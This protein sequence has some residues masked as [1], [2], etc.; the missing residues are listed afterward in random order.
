MNNTFMESLVVDRTD[1]KSIKTTLEKIYKLEVKT[2][3]R[4]TKE[5]KREKQNQKRRSGDFKLKNLLGITS[6]DQRKT[7][8]GILG[9]LGN[10]FKS[11]LSIGAT[12]LLV[13][14]GI[15]LVGGAVVAY[16]KSEEFRK[17]VNE[18]VL[19]PLGEA[20]AK[21]A[22][23]LMMAAIM[24]AK[25]IIKN[26]TPGVKPP[27]G[28][29]NS[30]KKGKGKGKGKGKPKGSGNNTN[31][32]GTGTSTPPKIKPPGTVVKKPPVVP[33]SPGR[34]PI[35]G[36]T[37]QPLPPTVQGTTPARAP[38]IPKPK[39]APKITPPK[40]SALKNI[41]GGLKS[42]LSPASLK[43]LGLSIAVDAAVEKLILDPAEKEMMKM[44]NKKVAGMSEEEKTKYLKKKVEEYKKEKKYQNHWWH[45]VDKIHTLGAPTQSEMKTDKIEKILNNFG[46]QID[47]KEI[48]IEE[49]EPEMLQTGGITG[50]ATGDPRAKLGLLE[51]RDYKEKSPLM[52]SPVKRQSGGLVLFAGHTD[53]PA[54]HP[55]PGTDAPGTDLQ[56]KYRPTAE[57]HFANAVG[58]AA[59]SLAQK[60]NVPLSFR[61]AKGQYA[62]TSD[63]NSNWAQIKQIRRGGGSAIDLHYDAYGYEG[64]RLIQGARGVISNGFTLTDVEKSVRNKFGKHPTSG[65]F[66]VPIV[67]LDTIN[68]APGNTNTYARMLVDSV[69]NVDSSSSYQDLKG[70][71]TNTNTGSTDQNQ[72]L[73]KT[74]QRTLMGTVASFTNPVDMISNLGKAV[75]NFGGAFGEFVGSAL[76]MTAS[77][78]NESQGDQQKLQTGGV[79]GKPIKMKK[80]GT[81]SPT[82]MPKDRPSVSTPAPEP[83]KEDK[84]HKSIPAPRPV[85]RER[86]SSTTP[87]V[88]PAPN[89]SITPPKTSKFVAPKESTPKTAP[90]STALTPPK[91]PTKAPTKSSKASPIK[92]QTTTPQPTPQP[93]Q[94]KV[95][96]TPVSK[97]QKGGLVSLSQNYHLNSMGNE[98]PVIIPVEFPSIPV[99]GTSTKT[100]PGSFGGVGSGVN[101]S[102]RLSMG[103]AFS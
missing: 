86:Q 73:Q 69:K 37:G 82:K 61:P 78:F 13:A 51:N 25:F 74:E 64:G 80:G 24:K 63:P 101:D 26:P 54:G 4:E 18:K 17:H 92:S 31:P 55:Q 81:P 89:I 83:V 3:K 16:I 46:L 27:T 29:G 8:K 62:S 96:R 1:I 34:S 71:S 30:N 15:G 76:E 9:L 93:Q 84:P 79:V 2:E 52:Q 60:E 87:Q 50:D 58:R 28:S 22:P 97:M 35:L 7:K 43:T 38:S 42:L 10:I 75:K 85:K 45:T 33:V 68:K 21:A 19:T 41:G 103:A 95:K 70:G 88:P 59:D 72:Q 14:A 12:P 102:Y 99:R 67:E 5:A 11:I 47:G 100:T 36:P 65:T 20:M 23:G 56:G 44:I 48:E 39:A 91:S 98:L 40:T 32:T 77:T 66:G 57:Q 6:N 49:E 90:P 94:P 53:V